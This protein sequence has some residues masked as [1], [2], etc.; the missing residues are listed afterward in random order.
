MGEKLNEKTASLMVTGGFVLDR[1]MQETPKKSKN[2]EDNFEV[3][4]RTMN[5]E[6]RRN[7]NEVGQSC[8]QFY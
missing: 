4:H 5:R 1:L 2:Q 7:A 3:K 8:R 6:F